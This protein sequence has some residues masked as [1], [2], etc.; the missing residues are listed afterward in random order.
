MRKEGVRDSGL[1][2]RENKDNPIP[3]SRIPKPRTPNPQS[4]IPNPSI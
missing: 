1:G 2:A 4:L 3:E